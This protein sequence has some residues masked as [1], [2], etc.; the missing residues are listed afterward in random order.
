[1]LLYKVI[2]LL[3]LIN[4]YGCDMNRKLAPQATAQP[5]PQET[6]KNVVIYLTRASIENRLSYRVVIWA[7]GTVDFNRDDVKRQGRLSQEQ[8]RQLIN[9]FE[10]IDFFSFADKYAYYENC[11]QSCVEHPCADTGVYLTGDY[12][13]ATTSFTYN[14]QSKSV[15]HYRGCKESERLKELTKLENKIDEVV[16]TQQW[17]E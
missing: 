2:P 14:G 10:A 11:P 12:S 8:M 6:S 15:L 9:A 13:F 4:S 17:L 1:M 3:L 7:D 16:N 5:T